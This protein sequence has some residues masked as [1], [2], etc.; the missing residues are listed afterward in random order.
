M[1]RGERRRALSG[2]RLDGRGER[3]EEKRSCK[4]AEVCVRSKE[5]RVDKEGVDRRTEERGLSDKRLGDKD[6]GEKRDTFGCLSPPVL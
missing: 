5:N 6:A 1:L 2:S 4:E 3:V